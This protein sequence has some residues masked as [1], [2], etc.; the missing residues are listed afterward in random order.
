MYDINVTIAQGINICGF[1]FVSG[2]PEHLAAIC[3]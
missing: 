1:I 2:I 3:I